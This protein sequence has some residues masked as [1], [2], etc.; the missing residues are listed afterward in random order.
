MRLEERG[1]AKVQVPISGVW[2]AMGAIL[3]F[4]KQ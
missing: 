1:A 4:E 3:H 2:L